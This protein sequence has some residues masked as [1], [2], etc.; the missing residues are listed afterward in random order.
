MSVNLQLEWMEKEEYRSQL[1]PDPSYWNKVVCK[2]CMKT[3][4]IS[5]MGEPAFTESHD[6]SKKKK[7][8]NKKKKSNCS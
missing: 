5:T 6:S 2:L 8:K 4:A 3:F 7:Q 1:N